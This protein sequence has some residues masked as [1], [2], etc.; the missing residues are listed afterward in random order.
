MKF[1]LLLL[2]IGI[3]LWMIGKRLRGPQ[4]PRRRGEP[5]PPQ[6]MVECAHC[7]LHLPAAE[8][9]LEGPHVYCSD[10]HRLLGP[11]RS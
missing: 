5:K 9:V 7:G 2:V 4:S 1:L 3:G 11:R 6:A 10:A 8:A